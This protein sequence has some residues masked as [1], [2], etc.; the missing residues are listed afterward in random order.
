MEDA[1]N[2]ASHFYA[3][4]QLAF[5]IKSHIPYTFKVILLHQKYGKITCMFSKD[6]QAML[7]TSGSLIW[8]NV[9]KI[10]NSYRLMSIEIESHISNQH[11][12]FVH[13]VIKL[14]LFQ[15]PS[16]ISVPEFFDFLLYVWWHMD[17]FC[18][19]AQK[20]VL[21]RLF[22]MLD[23]L[24]KDVQVYKI[25]ILD[26][27][28]AVTYEKILLETYVASGWNNFYRLQNLQKSD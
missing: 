6:H 17:K 22:L 23:L 20:I 2:K 13:D 11:L 28:Q 14:C 19:K 18:S 26:P 12:S 21:L 15:L 16:K 9:E 4:M 7:L 24:D 5:V 1:L 10:H 3:T 27:M 8:C 25:A